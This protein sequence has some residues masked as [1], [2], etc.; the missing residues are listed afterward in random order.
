MKKKISVIRL[1]LGADGRTKYWPQYEGEE[2]LGSRPLDP[3]T[4]LH[5]ITGGGVPLEIACRD[6]YD[7]GIHNYESL[8]SDEDNVAPSATTTAIKLRR[9]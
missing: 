5:H 7:E 6:P 4:A 1:C 2:D 8:R 3:K 9:I